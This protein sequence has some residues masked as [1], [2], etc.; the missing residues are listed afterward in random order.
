MFERGLAEDLSTQSCLH[1][2]RR[3][4]CMK[5]WRPFCR[6]V[7]TIVHNDSPCCA[8]Q[9]K[10]SASHFVMVSLCSRRFT[11]TSLR[12]RPW[13]CVH[14]S[15]GQPSLLAVSHGA[16][17][18]WFCDTEEC[19]FQERTPDVSST[20]GCFVLCPVLDIA[21][22]CRQQNDCH[23]WTECQH[24]LILKSFLEML[25]RFLNK[26]CKRVCK[27]RTKQVMHHWSMTR[28]LLR[29]N[30]SNKFQKISCHFPSL[31]QVWIKR[32]IQRNKKVIEKWLWWSCTPLLDSN[33]TFA[34]TS[35][36]IA[37]DGVVIC[38][39]PS[40]LEFAMLGRTK[41]AL[42]KTFKIVNCF[43]NGVG[44]TKDWR[45]HKKAKFRMNDENARNFLSDTKFHFCSQLLPCIAF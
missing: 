40:D 21:K 5:N 42:S 8:K 7:V 26:L 31:S 30:C 39:C 13:W 23:F 34:A 10:T 32:G 35:W 38:L 4:F 27:H 17:T 9:N 16:S 24:K 18:N 20:Q 15:P 19:Q 12:H 45:L 22:H 11:Q 28:I 44:G 6:L 41:H 36:T 29:S 33:H 43:K 1:W 3:C 14:C 25:W 2:D 37:T